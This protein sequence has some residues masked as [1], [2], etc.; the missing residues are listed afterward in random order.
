MSIPYSNSFLSILFTF[1]SCISVFIDASE[2]CVRA[3]FDFGTLDSS[4]S[5]SYTIKTLQ[6][7]CGDDMAGPP[8][9]LQYFTATSGS[10]ASFNFPTNAA[11]IT[12]STTHL[13]SQHYT[14]CFRREVGKCGICFVP[15][16][17]P[18]TPAVSDQASFG[19]SVSSMDATAKSLQEGNCQNDW[20]W[21]NHI[22][23]WTVQDVI[24]FQNS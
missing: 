22:L 24:P 2:D 19:L 12:A 15:A 10:I 11:T 23:D 7:I 21:V 3:T 14:M 1:F 18:T 5:R 16:I 20:L 6:Y 17:V 13:V 8:D 4:T 9:C